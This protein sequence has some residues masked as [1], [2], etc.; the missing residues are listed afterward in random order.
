MKMFLMNGPVLH[1]LTHLYYCYCYDV[2]MVRD[3]PS[4]S[5]AFPY[6]R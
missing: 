5:T 1:A 2:C 4:S 6:I 3:K